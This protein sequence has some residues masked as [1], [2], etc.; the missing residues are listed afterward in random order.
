M[1]P[2]TIPFSV[3]LLRQAN[4]MQRIATTVIGKQARRGATL[5]EF[6]LTVPIVFLLFFAA[7]DFCRLSMLTHTIEQAAYEG[8]R[9]GCLPGA[10][11]GQATQTAQDELA[12]VGVRMSQ[13]NIE[14]PVL[15]SSTPEVSVII[16]V[17]LEMNG[18][19]TPRVLTNSHI[20]RRCTL[21]RQFINQN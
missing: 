1:N 10:T 6:A 7:F 14:P 21:T 18:W 17:P 19:L 4:I 5:V 2:E 3:Y 15:V 8:A 9:R 13:I 20:E 12:R 11:A 16:R